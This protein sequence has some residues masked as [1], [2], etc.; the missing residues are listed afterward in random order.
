MENSSNIKKMNNDKLILLSSIVCLIYFSLLIIL[1]I[2]DIKLVAVGALVE[3]LTIPFIIILLLLTGY[4]INKS[5]KNKFNVKSKYFISTIV[6]LVT[7][8]LLIASTI[9]GK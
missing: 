8:I 6:F 4:S 1:S 9:Y 7:I 5:I 2:Y 3:L